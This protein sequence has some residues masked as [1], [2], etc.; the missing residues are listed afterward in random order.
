[1][2]AWLFMHVQVLVRF[3][4]SAPMVLWIIADWLLHKKNLGGVAL[5]YFALHSVAGVV[6][7]SGFYPPA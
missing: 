3:L 6:L 7:Y 4:T 1:V 2:Y 5:A